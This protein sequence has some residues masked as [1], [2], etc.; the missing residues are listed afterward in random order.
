MDKPIQ[1]MWMSFST[2]DEKGQCENGFSYEVKHMSLYGLSTEGLL[3]DIQHLDGEKERLTLIMQPYGDFAIGNRP[4]IMHI[5]M[6]GS[7]PATRP[8]SKQEFREI[9]GI[10][11]LFDEKRGHYVSNKEKS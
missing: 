8:I 5:R 7:Y 2:S 6:T 9:V 10:G 1:T 4:R 11:S 3:F